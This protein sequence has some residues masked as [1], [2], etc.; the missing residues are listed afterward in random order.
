MPFIGT[1]DGS[2]AGRRTLSTRMPIVLIRDASSVC[3]RSIFE[4][5]R[6]VPRFTIPWFAPGGTMS[7]FAGQCP[8]CGGWIHFTIRGKQAITAEEAAQLPNSRLTGTPT[9]LFY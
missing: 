6:M 8:A 4:W 3:R 9:R 5:K 2:T 1:A 7:G